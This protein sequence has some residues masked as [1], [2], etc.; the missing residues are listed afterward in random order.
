VKP[1]VASQARAY[2]IHVSTDGN[3]WYMVASTKRASYG[4]TIHNLAP[5]KARYVKV[6]VT[7]KW[8]GSEYVSM[9]GIQVFGTD[10]QT[11]SECK[12]E[13]I[14]R[15][16]FVGNS[17]TCYYNVSTKVQ[18]MLERVGKKV[19][20]DL[21]LQM[22]Q[23]LN[24]HI[25][26]PHT[27]NTILNG[28]YDYV[29]LQD[30]AGHFSAE[31][32]QEGAGLLY[33]NFIKKTGATPILYMIWAN[34]DVL[35]DTQRLVTAAYVA[36][37]Q[38]IGARLAPAGECWLD[39]YQKGYNWYRDNVHANATGAYMAAAN[40]FYA[41]SGEQEPLKISADDEVVIE[42][43]LD[44]DLVNDIHEKACAYVLSRRMPSTAYNI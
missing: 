32:L 33:N 11:I 36:V 29:V 30:K 20:I 25:S 16:L 44:V 34:E 5:V 38:K 15:I 3:D 21:L 7:E 10:Y 13:K 17:L 2:E 37:A 35:L 42:N 39:F 18:H 28:N 4:K 8:V 19:Q 26:L 43:Q 23:T 1:Y 24:H 6:L 40:I 41:I 31:A 27:G 9:Y 12:Q 14:T 22:G